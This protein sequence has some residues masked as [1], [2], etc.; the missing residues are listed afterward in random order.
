MATYGRNTPPQAP[1]DSKPLLFIENKGQISNAAVD[2][3]LQARDVTVYVSNTG[4]HY[5]WA[6][7]AIGKV[8]TY[9]MD[10]VLQGSNKKAGAIAT[11]KQDY[12]EHYYLGGQRISSSSF[13]K[14]TYANVYPNIDWVVYIKGA[15][16]EYDFIVHPG[17]D[18]D[19]IKLKYKGATQLQLNNGALTARTPFGTVTE[20]APYS[21]SVNSKKKLQSAFCLK[22]DILS[23]KVE[24]AHDTYVIDPLLGWSTYYGYSQQDQV[25]SMTTDAAGNIYIAGL[26]QSTSNIASTGAYKD[27]INGVQ[28]AF[29]AKFN[30][31]GQRLWA[32]Y[33]GGNG[34]QDMFT[35][36]TCDGSGNVYAGGTTN[37]ATGIGTPTAYDMTYGGGTD[38]MLVKLNSSGQ[39]IWGT[40]YGGVGTEQGGYIAYDHAYNIYICGSTTTSTSAD[41]ADGVNIH[42]NNIAPGGA[43]GF[44]A[45]FDSA[46]QRI[47]GTYYCG[48]NTAFSTI[49]CDINHN[50]YAA[51]ATRA[52]TGIHTA[53]AHDTTFGGG[54]VPDG[55]VVKFDSAGSREWGTYFGGPN[56]D[57]IRFLCTDLHNHLYISGSTGSGAEIAT[58]GSFKD[59]I[60]AGTDGFLARMDVVTG[61]V[62]WSTYYGGDGTDDVRCIAVKDESRIIIGGIT[63]SST[64][65]ATIGSMNDTIASPSDDGFIAIFD[66]SGT[67]SYGSYFGG[68]AQ[69]NITGIAFTDTGNI[70]IAG[71][72]ASLSGVATPGSFKDTADGNL[73]GFLAKISEDKITFKRPFA[74]TVLCPGDTF[75]VAFTTL[76]NFNA[77]NVFT[78]E[79]S[80]SSG[81]FSSSFTLGSTVAFYD[82]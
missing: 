30:A 53:N 13:S 17:G 36:I 72:T 82:K 67:P 2:Y 79:L 3:K 11:G 75:I 7:G 57:N 18:P 77:G 61:V 32:T 56:T 24:R 73:D 40:Y 44:L 31:A 74:D 4:L 68:I 6:N 64:G 65:I 42:Q 66:S 80:D 45:K 48:N 29:I 41:I 27:T 19:N 43:N 69:E 55:F 21:Y 9:R 26:T 59:T 28:D 1:P 14:I 33:Y 78:A 76:T 10:V 39:L 35:S 81:N 52:T 58:S 8:E 23:F 71:N 20:Q 54:P 25:T 49:H 38:V 70:Y 12:S 62:N 22:A 5:Q 15:Q 50:V 47:W 16:L 51:G 60:N 34:S 46:G 37:S 63:Q